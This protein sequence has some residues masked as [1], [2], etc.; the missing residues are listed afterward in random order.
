M[1]LTST[2]LFVVVPTV[3]TGTAMELE[4]M[5]PDATASPEEQRA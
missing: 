1:P 5:R 4:R 2:T 3:C